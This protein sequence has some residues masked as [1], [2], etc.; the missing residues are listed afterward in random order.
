M[1]LSILNKNL[2]SKKLILVFI[3]IIFLF[4][5]CIHNRLNDELKTY[6]QNGKIGFKSLT[7]KVIIEPKFENTTDNFSEYQAVKLND[8]WGLINRKGN[9]IIPPI[10]EW[11]C[12]FDTYGL[13]HAK[14]NGYHGFINKK[15]KVIVPFIY[16]DASFFKDGL[17]M[18]KNNSKWGFLNTKGKTIIPF[19]YDYFSYTGWREGKIGACKNYK[20]GFIDKQNNLVIPFDY[21]DVSD[22]SEGLACVSKSY[23]V[24]G[25]IDKTN[26]IVIPFEYEGPNY[27]ENNF[28][29]GL[30]RVRQNG[31]AG[32]INKAGKIIYPL[33][34]Y[35][36][37]PICKGY[38]FIEIENPK[39][40]KKQSVLK[41]W[42]HQDGTYDSIITN[43]EESV[44]S[45]YGYV[46]TLG[47][48]TLIDYDYNKYVNYNW[49]VASAPEEIPDYSSLINKNDTNILKHYT[50]E[51]LLTTGLTALRQEPISYPDLCNL[52]QICIG[53]GLRL[54]GG[55]YGE[56]ICDGSEGWDI[57][58]EKTI[59]KIISNES[60]RQITWNW[61]KPYYKKSFLTT[62]P[63]VQKT[64]KGIVQYLK[65]YINTYDVAK[66]KV[67]LRKSE[68]KF[69]YY[70]LNGHYDENRKIGAFMDR[71]ILLHKVIT[72]EDAKKWINIISNEIEEW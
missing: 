66:V 40:L 30:A 63:L 9:F 61:I 35:E 32:F 22:F 1:Q 55:N 68:K 27:Y 39:K 41:T 51:K 14:L 71:L 49:E 3:S 15:G 57:F 2:K 21:Y 6:K 5:H 33:K 60:L 24:C 56:F 10:Y 38:A 47:N 70:D 19:E 69:A 52:N 54:S 46:D 62:H 25:Y 67:H 42:Y 64:Y 13:A 23:N 26:T 36:L 17:V 43:Y 11:L 59:Y 58:K 72:V 18:L 29:N 8:K 12:S 16:S 4:N 31:K 28:K 34:Y 37:N 65:N 53:Y 20:W 48:E 45:S 50:L 7:G 44:I